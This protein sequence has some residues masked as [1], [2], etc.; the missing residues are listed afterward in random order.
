MKAMGLLLGMLFSLAFTATASL[1][2]ITIHPTNK[3]VAPSIA[4]TFTVA[5]SNASSYQWRFNGVD[6][7]W[8]TNASLVV[9]NAQTN[10][11]G[12]YM[13]VAKNVV[14]V[15][16]SQMAYLSVVWSN[17][18]VPFYSTN[19]PG[20]QAQYSY[21]SC[22][23]QYAGQPIT[24]GT[25]QL[26]AGPELDQLVPVGATRPVRSGYFGPEGYGRQVSTVPP[27]S[28]CY[29]RVDITYTPPCGGN[30]VT[31]PSAVIGLIAG[32]NS[33][34]VPQPTS[35]WFPI[36]I[37][38]PDYDRAVLYAPTSR[39]A[40]LGETMMLYGS[41]YSFTGNPRPFNWRKDG[42]IIP[43][44]TNSVFTTTPVLTLTNLTE[45][46]CGV[47]DMVGPGADGITRNKIL[48]SVQTINGNGV[49]KSPR[50]SGTNFACDLEGAASRRYAILSSTNLLNW[51]SNLTVTVGALTNTVSFSTVTAGEQIRFYRASL[52]PIPMY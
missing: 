36:Y 7:P 13:V 29:C 15:T 20:A 23:G 41:Y 43:G 45:S 1:P 12:Y 39:V 5:S 49:L 42:Q 10:N 31:Q 25:A 14:G 11:A 6:I 22:S 44:A 34:P 46:D 33:L 24:N 3:V 47:Y 32:G 51:T 26:F 2:V 27:G 28:T 48:L 17:G 30:A 4:A 21:V 37:E 35:L 38:W 40:V 18:I 8:G 9:T 50:V 16:P 19:I 52:I